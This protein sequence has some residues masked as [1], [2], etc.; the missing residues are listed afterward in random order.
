[1]DTVTIILVNINKAREKANAEYTKYLS[2]Y[3]AKDNRTIK[4]YQ[5][6]RGLCAG[7]DIVLEQVDL[8]QDED[9]FLD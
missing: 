9:M 1:M 4:A 2:R 8:S 3:G 6:Y 7:C 5:Y